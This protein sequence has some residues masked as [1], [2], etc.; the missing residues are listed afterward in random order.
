MDVG[1]SHSARRGNYWGRNGVGQNNSSG[2]IF[3]RP[4][5]QQKIQGDFDYLPRHSL[6]AMA[7]R[8]ETLVP[9]IQSR[10]LA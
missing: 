2:R 1:A 10:G 6:E 8:T 4:S 5:L 9:R 3:G 7:E